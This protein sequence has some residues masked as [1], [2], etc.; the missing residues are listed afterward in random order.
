MLPMFLS[1][2][3]VLGIGD[4]QVRDWLTM[5]TRLEE[6]RRGG[7]DSGWGGVWR[8]WTS[9][10]SSSNIA[11]CAGQISTIDRGAGS[12]QLVGPDAGTTHV[13]HGLPGGVRED[14]N[15]LHI[16]LRRATNDWIV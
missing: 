10:N 5:S 12:L 14:E 7:G 6:D 11:R 4:I 2:G 8:E 15:V 13:I 3:K 1:I 16:V 9:S